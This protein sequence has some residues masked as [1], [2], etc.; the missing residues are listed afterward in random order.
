MLV[1]FNFNLIGRYSNDPET[2]KLN[3][4]IKNIQK[5]IT[6]LQS[7]KQKIKKILVK[8]KNDIS[9]GISNPSS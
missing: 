8:S 7:E 5:E 6:S 3:K 4:E 9:Q 2:A 1:I